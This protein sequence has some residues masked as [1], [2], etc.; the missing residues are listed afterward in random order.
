MAGLIST[1]KFLI[2]LTHTKVTFLP[3]K[4][5]DNLDNSFK[6]E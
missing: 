2:V 5:R 3:M 4:K 1:S 6:E